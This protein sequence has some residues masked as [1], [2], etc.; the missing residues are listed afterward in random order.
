MFN[1]VL[2]ANRGEIACRIIRS[3]QSL[4]VQTVA[5]YS[6]A[7][8]H[9][10]HV[11]QADEAFE[12]GA[13]KATDSY[14]NMEKVLY[15]AKKAKVDAIHPGYGFLSENA[16][17]CRR[18]REEGIT[19]IGPKPETLSIMGDKVAARKQMQAAG[20][21]V[22][23]GSDGPVSSADEAVSFAES[24]GYPVMV[25]AAA[26]GGGI[27][28][29]IAQD[30]EALKKAFS[31]N[32]RRAANYFGS[33][34]LYIEK[35][36]ESPRHIEVQVLGDTYGNVIHLGERDCSIQRRHQKV[37]EE[38]PATGLSEGLRQQLRHAAI[39][40]AKSLQY[41]SAGTLEFLVEEDEFYFLEMNTRLQVEHPVTE[42]VTNIDIVQEQLHVG[43]GEALSVQQSEVD[44][45]G[46]AIEARIY[47]EDPKTFFPSPGTIEVFDVPEGE[48][49]RLDTG[50]RSGTEV[51]P[52]YDPMLAKLIGIG[53]T[54]AEAIAGLRQAL[55]ECNIQ[56]IRTNIPFLQEIT[57][58]PKVVNGQV[59][60]N[61]VKEHF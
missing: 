54:R 39:Q 58:H 59:T 29:E 52:F 33:G 41:E 45:Q 10:L 22:V 13:A 38:A 35:A 51:T 34:S 4:G 53:E 24:I 26:G 14:L 5:I 43:A 17:F 7:D 15:I 40:A 8:R 9:A 36:L 18:C 48:H 49:I 21:P 31:S 37:L 19:F 23:P 61:F 6:E 16:D 60:T 32:Q 27:G 28:M 12:A 3:C 55:D 47:A 42:V 44:W 57:R 50:V 46:Y 2:I 25:K 1:K 20:V 11:E 56:G 30:A